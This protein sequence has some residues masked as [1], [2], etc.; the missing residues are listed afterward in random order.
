MTSNIW[1]LLFIVL[2][3]YLTTHEFCLSVLINHIPS[4]PFSRLGLSCSAREQEVNHLFPAYSPW[5]RRCGLQA[6]PLL[7]SCAGAH[8]SLRR[9]CPCRDY[10]KGQV[11]LCQGCL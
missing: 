10:M 1:S 6:E 8:P 2:L 4:G 5:G 9:V 3:F 11:A 7:F